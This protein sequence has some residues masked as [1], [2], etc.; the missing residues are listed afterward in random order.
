MLNS[1]SS[2][3]I[4]NK[5]EEIAL[6]SIINV[7][8][9]RKLHV[10]LLTI[11][12]LLSINTV[13]AQRQRF[14]NLTVDD[15]TIDSVLPRFTYSI[16]LGRQYADSTYT[17]EIRYPEFLAMNRT[18]SLRYREL[19]GGRP[20]PAMPQVEQHI[21]VDRKV[22]K[23]E[24][25][26]V[27]VVERDGKKQFL[28]SFMIA[29]TATPRATQTK[30][31]PKASAQAS[32][33]TESTDADVYAAHSVLASGQWVKIRVP[34][35][36]V[37]QLTEKLVKQCGFSDISKVK[38]YG[39]GGNLID[40]TLTQANLRATDDL[41]EVPLCVV[42][43]RRLFYANGPVSWSSSTATKRTRNPYSDYGYYFLTENDNAPLTID[44]VS[45]VNQSPTDDDYHLLYEVDNY[46]WYQGGRNLFDSQT[47]NQG[48]SRSYTFTKPSTAQNATVAIGVTAG[49]TTRVQM[50][51]NGTE[52]GTATIT[53][54]SYDHGAETERTYNISDLNATD[55]ISVKVLSGGPAH[56][57][58]ISMTYDEP[59]SLP[60]LTSG[61][62]PEPEY[63][64]G[65]VNQDHHADAQADM[66]IIIPTSQKLLEQ[67]QRLADYHRTHD[68]LR[69]NIVP[70][71][72]LYNEFSS[73]TP[74]ASAYRHYLKMLYD[75]A[76]SDD[77]MPRYLLLFGDCVW[78]SRMRTSECSGLDADD[79][80]LAHE[81]ENSFN[82][83]NCYVNDGW[84]TLLDDGEGVNP[85]RTDKEDVAVGRIPVTTVSD[86]K[87]VVDK[88]LA[89][90]EN[91]NAGDWENTLMFMGDDGNNN[92]HMRDV[93]ETAETIM[94]LYPGYQVKK[95][96][97]DAYTR[98]TTS[99][100][101]SYPEVSQI[102]KQQQAAGALVMDYAGHGVEYQLS[103]E[104][105]LKIA[106][107]KAFSNQNLPL[108]ITASC[109]VMPFDAMK[110]TIGEQALLNSK[111]GAVAFWG[112]TRTV[113]AYYNKF[114]NTSFLKH[115]LSWTGGKPTTI[116]EAQRLA[117]N[118]MIT[119][120]QDRTLNKL[121]YSLL[122]DPA[123]E[124]NLPRMTAVVDSINGVAV[125]T[126][127]AIELKAGSVA[128][129]KGHIEYQ[130]QLVT[131]F[132]G[133]V[134][135]TVRDTRELITCKKQESTSTS[136]FQYYDRTKTLYNG[137]DSV[138]A[139][140]FTFTFAV[141]LDINYEQGAGQITL[142][143]ASN[144]H[145]MLANGHN[146]NFSLNGTETYQNDSIGPSIYC[147]LNS[148]SF[149]DGGRVNTTPYFVANVT[150]KD[151]INATGA[152]IGHDLQL[153]IDGQQAM[154]YNLNSN[155]TFDFGTYTSGQT[156]YNI[157]E[158][159]EGKHQLK[160]RAWDMLNNSSTA[161]LNF[162]VVKGLQPEIESISCTNNPATTSTT[163]IVTHNFRDADVDVEISVFDAS[164]RELWRHS[165]SGVS[166]GNAYTVDWDLCTNSGARLQTGVY[167]YR[168]KLSAEGSSQ[169]SKAKKLIVVNN[170]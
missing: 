154:T 69:V 1:G 107:F 94:G 168:V 20:T 149:S 95:V 55:T 139:G 141:P 105:V 26:F 143:A 50:L 151:G 14:F 57:D 156:Y 113:Y 169:A 147:Y 54:G 43:N 137:S 101:N 119:S 103:H 4:H 126:P 81:S 58:Y 155:F 145:Q 71:D 16:P 162:T 19:M 164:G 21:V 133:K 91:A 138:R 118:D 42:G 48:A 125:D 68:S 135:A 75:R 67:A 2:S 15:V 85:D 104:A 64:Y 92:L 106:D 12:L 25:S 163:F 61:T 150:D 99:T 160:F 146:E 23:L 111:G 142:F 110:E 28:V 158:L 38:V 121:Q 115:V 11:G 62:F 88:I 46:A 86:A 47:I 122:G 10:I 166:T 39:Y 17:V 100:G 7:L 36:G 73:G 96:M 128:K 77:D 31:A 127:D 29:L 165:E 153:I 117:K 18:D 144:D 44:S 24:L 22:G 108:W 78:D 33:Q 89:Y 148:P 152:G 87:T 34:S 84:L 112:T 134:T 66:V 3:R 70:A 49:T 132:N 74:D 9:M 63:V 93:N 140:E 130:N 131:S 124:L 161:T 129:V 157:P 167:L 72:E 82:E 79:Y 53:L 32:L 13:Y 60:S 83:I 116:G 123:M 27:P 41:T 170:K 76:T 120:G 35:T 40:E 114:V 5:T 6:F 98:V 97:W 59:F 52:L 51:R 56:L 102:I 80:L 37:Y 109:D 65:I 159:S 8:N 90:C 136:A 30:A 45:F